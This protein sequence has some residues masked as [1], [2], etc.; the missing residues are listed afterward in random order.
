M[1]KQYGYTTPGLTPAYINVQALPEGAM[2]ITVRAAGDG[3]STGA[4]AHIDL[5]RSEYA[6]LREAMLEVSQP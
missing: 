1:S 2:R 6:K 5:P 4:T 3:D